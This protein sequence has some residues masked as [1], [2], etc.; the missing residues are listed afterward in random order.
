MLSGRVPEMYLVIEP[1][2]E[3]EHL[4]DHADPAGAAGVVGVHTAPEP[5]LE[6]SSAQV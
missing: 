6:T 5:N 3:H 4:S 2:V 1:D